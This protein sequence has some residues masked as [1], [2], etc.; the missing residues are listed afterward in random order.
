MTDRDLTIEEITELWEKLRKLPPV[1]FTWLLRPEPAF[2]TN[3]VFRLPEIGT[4]LL[5][6]EYAEAIDSTIFLKEKLQ[7]SEAL[8]VQ[9]AEMTAGQTSNSSWF[10]VRQHRITASN[11]GKVLNAIKI[12]R[13]PPSVRYS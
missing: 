13:F 11:F 8:I 12:N 3:P 5:S 2:V 1:G 6:K 4:I 9:I 7:L 10:I